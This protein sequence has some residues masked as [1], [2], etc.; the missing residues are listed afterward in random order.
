MRDALISVPIVR[1]VNALCRM[2]QDM[3]EEASSLS[4]N[5]NQVRGE[6]YNRLLSFLL[7]RPFAFAFPLRAATGTLGVGL[8]LLVLMGASMPQAAASERPP[9]IVIL[10]ADDLGRADLGYAGSDIRTPNIDALVATGVRLDR[11]YTCPVCSPTRAG[12][13]TGRWPIRYGLMRTVIPP[14]SDY[15]LPHEERTLAET[16]ADGGYGRRG[17]FGKWHLGHAQRAYL[18]PQRGF[19]HFFGHYNGALDY[20]THEREGEVD[21]HRNDETVKEPGYTTDLIAREAVAFIEETPFREPFFLYVAFN[22]PHTPYQAKAE[23]IARYPERVGHKRTYAAMVDAM[24]Q[25]IGAILS[26]IEKRTDADNTFV[27][28]FSDNG[29]H[30]P[31]ASNAPMRDGKFSVYEGGIR[32][33]AAARWPAGGL[34]GGRVSTEPMGYIDV[35]PTILRIADLPLS[36]RVNRDRPFD[37]LD[38]LD[39]MRG[40]KPAP[41]RPWFSYIA[42]QDT[43]QAAV[44]YEEWKLILRGEG[45]LDAENNPKIATELYNIEDDP[46][47]MIN[48]ADVHPEK[49]DQLRGQLLEFGRMQKAG[50][51]AYGTGRGKF[52]APRDWKITR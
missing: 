3:N 28:F 24:D 41:T 29:G 21:W 25:A 12:L 38:M 26:A 34:K 4:F 48:L 19:T 45:V 13:L 2:F 1:A 49:I 5:R 20:F 27:L 15:G 23:D 37:G 51:S 30:T 46:G 47:E 40:K 33:A 36:E 9:N 6:I 50:V 31:I 18:P 43:E 22:A 14:W 32:V 8:L 44:H 17:L 52:R 35:F 11:F 10:L 16:L 7:A 39:V 42:P